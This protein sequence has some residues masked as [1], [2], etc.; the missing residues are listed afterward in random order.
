MFC[1]CRRQ[2]VGSG[3]AVTADT[4][5]GS[6]GWTVVARQLLQTQLERGGARRS[7]YRHCAALPGHVVWVVPG[8]R[9]R[10][11]RRSIE[12]S[13]T[14]SVW[15]PS[16]G[17]F[18]CLRKL[19]LS[20]SSIPTADRMFQKSSNLV[21][22]IQNELYL[23]MFKYLHCLLADRSKCSTTLL[24]WIKRSKYLFLNSE[25]TLLRGKWWSKEHCDLSIYSK[26]S[27]SFEL[28]NNKYHQ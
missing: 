17:Y 18:L 23:W 6:P 20:V 26:C 19:S 2:E 10:A 13:G 8:L 27:W 4:A 5:A 11:R 16:S 24:H 1:C 28:Q 25:R 21:S 7:R 22:T 14:H 3:Q 15:P 9:S 12:T